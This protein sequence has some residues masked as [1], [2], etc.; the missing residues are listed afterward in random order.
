MNLF[1]DCE[2]NDFGG[3]LISMAL[4]DKHGHDWY[5]V[6]ACQNPTPW[7]AANVMPVL[8]EA[9]VLP[10]HFKHSLQQYLHPYSAI[11]V[12]A[13]WPED[14][15]HFCQALIVGPGKRIATPPLTMEVRRDLDSSA[16]AIPHNALADAHAIRN[17][18]LQLAASSEAHR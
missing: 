3:A 14:I 9:P 18:Y 17:Q 10:M 15:A 6:L 8:G 11:H 5:R 4:V 12:I 2:F 7:V 1:L 16:S 13:D